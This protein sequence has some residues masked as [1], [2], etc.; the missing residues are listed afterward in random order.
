M[1]DV[2]DKNEFISMIG[3]LITPF[4]YNV[5]N[6]Q[7]G[8]KIDNN[9]YE[10]LFKC[11]RTS[12]IT[13]TLT[14]I[15]FINI[16]VNYLNGVDTNNKNVQKYKNIILNFIDRHQLLKDICIKES[17]IYS[18]LKTYEENKQKYNQIEKNIL[19]F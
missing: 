18:K 13:F 1:N 19:I 12:S 7:L 2:I 8:H 3:S 10:R 14:K 15:E 6:Q 16:I 11:T 17:N 5:F 4:E 9:T